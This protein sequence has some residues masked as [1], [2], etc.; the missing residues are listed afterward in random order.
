[1]TI[2]NDRVLHRIFRALKFN[3]GINLAGIS[4]ITTKVDVTMHIKIECIKHLWIICNLLRIIAVKLQ[5][6]LKIG[7]DIE[8]NLRAIPNNSSAVLPQ[9]VDAGGIPI[10][11]VHHNGTRILQLL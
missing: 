3:A 7:S 8:C 4:G 6:K 9:R 10:T 11:I 5:I 1:M 2:Y